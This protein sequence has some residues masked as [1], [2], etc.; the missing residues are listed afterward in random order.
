MVTQ[1]YTSTDV[2]IIVPIG[3]RTK[4]YA[5][6]KICVLRHRGIVTETRDEFIKVTCYSVCL[7]TGCDYSVGPRIERAPDVVT[8]WAIERPVP[9]HACPCTY[10]S[11]S[12][13]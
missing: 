5:W 7:G 4:S 1:S 8:N 11:G 6:Q 2:S 10:V 12:G 3:I 13:L 9:A